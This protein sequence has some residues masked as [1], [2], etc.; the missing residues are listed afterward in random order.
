MDE[1]KSNLS[2]ERVSFLR[3]KYGSLP[4]TSLW[5]LVAKLEEENERLRVALDSKANLEE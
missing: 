4:L 2:L 5:E 1:D 3:H